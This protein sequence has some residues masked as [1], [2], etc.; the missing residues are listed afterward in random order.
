MLKRMRVIVTIILFAASLT[1]FAGVQECQ[2]EYIIDSIR[3]C[4]PPNTNYV[5]GFT[6]VRQPY[7][8]NKYITDIPVIKKASMDKLNDAI[9]LRVYHRC[10]INGICGTASTKN[11]NLVECTGY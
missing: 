5:C 6:Y 8:S 2:R 10:N 3:S 7:S 1:A 4:N 11:P 9:G